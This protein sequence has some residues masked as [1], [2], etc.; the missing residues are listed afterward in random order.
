MIKPIKNKLTWL[1]LWLLRLRR[2]GKALRAFKRH[3]RVVLHRVPNLAKPWLVFQLGA[4]NVKLGHIATSIQKAFFNNISIYSR[5]PTKHKRNFSSRY[6]T[7]LPDRSKTQKISSYCNSMFFCL[8][9]KAAEQLKP[10]N[11]PHFQGCKFFK[12]NGAIF[13]RQ[14]ILLT[15]R[16]S[17]GTRRFPI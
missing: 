15:P 9:I 11:I 4:C 13:M 3:L 2:A 1:N 14:L 6:R 7:T 12:L 17:L 16:F 10:A 5:S 8:T